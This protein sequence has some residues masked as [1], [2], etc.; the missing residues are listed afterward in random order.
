MSAGDTVAGDGELAAMVLEVVFGGERP[1]GVPVLEL[2]IA[3]VAEEGDLAMRLVEIAA[4][5]NFGVDFLIVVG[6][7]ADAGRRTVAVWN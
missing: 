5:R 6:V 1:E 2:E 3:C 7:E 4:G